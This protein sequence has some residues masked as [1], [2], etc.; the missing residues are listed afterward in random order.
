MK[1][2]GFLLMLMVFAGAVGCHGEE[3]GS[4]PRRTVQ[5]DLP[6]TKV[7]LYQ[8]GVGYI[9]RAGKLKGSTLNLRIRHDQVKDILKTLTVVD[10]SGGHA[11]SIALPV[12]KRR[13]EAMED[14]PPQVRTSGGI[15]TIAQAFRGA[16]CKVETKRGTFVGRLVGVEN[17]GNAKANEYRLTILE[18]GGV[19][20]V[21]RLSEI[22]ELKV[23]DRT[24]TVGLERSLDIALDKGTWKPVNLTIRLNH[25]GEHNL[26]V[27]YVVEM[28]IWKPAYRLIVG[29]K[30][31]NLLLQ[32]WSVVDNLS[33][34]EWNRVALSLTAGTPLAFM[35]DLYTPQG[36]RRPDLTPSE[37]YAER[38][39]ELGDS[40]YAEAEEAPAD[41]PAAYDKSELSSDDEDYNAPRSAPAGAAMYKMQPAKPA[42]RRDGAGYY[43]MESRVTLEEM[44]GSFNRMVSGTS[45]GSL[46]RYDI[47]ERV[48][49]PDRSSALVTLINKMVD[50]KDVLYHIVEQ[51]QDGIPYRAVRFKNTSGFVLEKGPIAIYKDG[52]FVGE[53]L[54]GVV[55]K[56]ATSFV[57]YA[58]EGKVL[59]HQDV[60]WENEG[61]KLLSII[62]G[63]ITVEER[64]VNI[65][66][67]TVTNRS[68]EE[69]ML[70]VRRNRRT[71]WTPV[72]SKDFIFEKDFYFVPIKVG[73]G[74]TKFKMRE[75][76]PVQRTYGITSYRSREIM[77]VLIKSPEL[78]PDLKKGLEEV[79]K[80][81]EEIQ[82]LATQMGTIEGNRR[83]LREQQ[84]D[85][86]RNLKVLGDKGNKDLRDKI[87][88]SLG[89]LADDLDKLNRRWVELNLQK[90]EKERR[91]Q[92][93]FK[94]ITFKRE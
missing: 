27:S 54:G 67:Y 26:V 35:Y 39:P 7:V 88:K 69:F 83:M 74:E 90:G 14:L 47:A 51:S 76:T 13:L 15:L 22:R 56:D 57:P 32:G 37:R 77:L 60:K 53:A 25:G 21:H 6:I 5:S 24:L 49:V 28:P 10:R 82:D 11:V 48:S 79:L 33:G 84:D 34:D 62:N 40:T 29:E 43:P 44:R 63:I 85:Q 80:L 19:L 71:N 72:D 3:D 61:E 94:A 87:E 78:R 4:L 93:L 70:Y 41:E 42:A 89:A 55:E 1:R 68:G 50:G 30:G 75:E 17:L 12:E 9:E 38:P 16:S 46:F 81:W 92:M 65:F 58:R 64:Q 66:E 45:V 18:S 52:Q 23:M 91:L 36:V 2:L 31:D 86:A 20:S 59:I 73:K 8:N